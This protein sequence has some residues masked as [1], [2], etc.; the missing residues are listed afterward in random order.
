[1]LEKKPSPNPGLHKTSILTGKRHRKVV[2]HSPPPSHSTGRAAHHPPCCLLPTRGTPPSAAVLPPPFPPTITA[3][4]LFQFPA[5]MPYWQ[6]ACPQTMR[7][8]SVHSSAAASG[9]WLGV[10]HSAGRHCVVFPFL[11]V[12]RQAEEALKRL[13][14]RP[15][16]IPQ[17][18]QQ[19]QS[20]ADPHVRQLAA[21]LLRK[22]TRKHWDKLPGEVGALLRLGTTWHKQQ[23]SQH[24]L[25]SVSAVP[26]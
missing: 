12:R 19:L 2:T 24:Q 3:W 13:S 11:Q 10:T 25:G 1:M 22:W 7:Y 21:V 4:L 18:V 8:C 17:L 9:W 20:A 6:P 26:R 14:H 5:L 15:D 16:V 23:A